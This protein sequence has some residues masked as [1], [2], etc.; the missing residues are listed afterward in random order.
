MIHN[1]SQTHQNRVDAL[2]AELNERIKLYTL[3][4]E[5]GYNSFKDKEFLRAY[6]EMLLDVKREM[7]G[8]ELS[9]QE[10]ISLRLLKGETNQIT[11]AA[12]PNKIIRWF[13]VM[14]TKLRDLLIDNTD[15][16]SGQSLT[17]IHGTPKG[18]EKNYAKSNPQQER[19]ESLRRQP[20]ERIIQPGMGGQGLKH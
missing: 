19:Q 7:S 4:V 18:E 11:R 13:V 2:K 14:G 5:N 15:L 8:K 17:N 16:T 12:Y 6:R 9:R 10:K 3:P 1:G 20:G